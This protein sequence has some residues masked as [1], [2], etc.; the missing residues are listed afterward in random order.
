M[1]LLA[2][3]V[4]TLIGGA[5]A[6]AQPQKVPGQELQWQETSFAN[7]GGWQAVQLWCDTPGRVLAVTSPAGSRG[8]VKLAQWVGGKTSIQDWQ[9]GRPDP[10]AGQVYTPLTPA[11]QTP[12][13]PPQYF[14]RSSNIENTIDPAYH[15]TRINEY[16][17]PAGRFQCRYVPQATVLAATAR[18]T[19][20]V[21]ESGGK[22]TYA[23]RNRDGAPGIQ[24]AGGTHTR[25][26][27]RE[28][29]VWDNAGYQYVLEVGQLA[30]PGGSLTVLKGGKTL[31]RE[32]LL[33]YSIS[34][35]K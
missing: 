27:G 10:G 17:V 13:K 16:V 8:D 32:E 5:Y 2:F 15:M 9:M 4:L 34:V 26:L 11:G 21:W 25:T 24:L 18:H 1:N 31:S 28:R 6:Q 30:H 23:S 7:I 12:G 14:I 33:A 3:L 22:V 19:V 35:Q 20:I 29:Y